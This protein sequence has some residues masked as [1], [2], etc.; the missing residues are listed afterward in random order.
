LWD[1][2]GILDGFGQDLTAELL[3]V[4]NVM[5]PSELGGKKA[6]FRPAKLGI[7]SIKTMM[8]ILRWAMEL[9]KTS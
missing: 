7:P 6:G 4:T 8:N 3:I 2:C 9:G 1:L 5:W